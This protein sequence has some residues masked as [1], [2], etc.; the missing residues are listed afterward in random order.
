M[1]V[2][3]SLLFRKYNDNHDEKGQFASGDSS[4]DSVAGKEGLISNT[5]AQSVIDE[6]KSLGFDHVG[7]GYFNRG[8]W[9]VS[10]G[11]DTKTFEGSNPKGGYFSGASS[12]SQV[13]SNTQSP[14][15][16]TKSMSTA[17]LQFT[18]SA[19]GYTVKA[20]DDE[21]ITNCPSRYDAMAQ[22]RK[23]VLKDISAGDVHVNAT[24]WK[25]RDLRDD[26]AKAMAEDSADDLA[27][28][29]DGLHETPD[30]D[31]TRDQALLHHF[32]TSKAS[33]LGSPIDCDGG[34][35]SQPV[36]LDHKADVDINEAISSGLIS[37]EDGRQAIADGV[38][39]A[40]IVTLM[41]QDGH[42]VVIV[43]ID[44]PSEIAKALGLTQGGLVV[45]FLDFLKAD[46]PKVLTEVVDDGNP[47]Q[48][49]LDIFYVP[50][51]NDGHLEW[52]EVRDLDKA[53]NEWSLFAPNRNVFLQ[54]NEDIVAGTWTQLIVMPWAFD[55]ELRKADGST[56]T[57][58]FPKGT[59]LI[60]TIWK[61]WAWQMIL[62]GRINGMSMGGM[63]KEREESPPK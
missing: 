40:D 47:D 46:R 42:Y 24:A 21:T 29:H 22:L 32:I 7:R 16:V 63:S 28:K 9:T 5:D 36:V 44:E 26:F 41:D 34:A 6:G 56:Q 50:N 23:E 18:R 1:T 15:T 25:V 60:G 61:N 4:G 55:A 54:H 35:L 57:H 30:E 33:E 10:Y 27:T 37:A 14:T 51:E 31:V 58:H 38:E 20:L 39:R 52:V 17:Y 59:V 19:E 12:W 8:G 53:V 3:L 2:D 11:T 13:D 43:P 45:P 62:D 49:T 48:Y